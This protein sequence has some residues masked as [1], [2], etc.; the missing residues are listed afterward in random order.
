[1]LVIMVIMGHLMMELLLYLVGQ[2]PQPH[3]QIGGDQMHEAEL[4]QR[5]VSGDVNLQ[6]QV[7]RPT[8]TYRAECLL[9]VH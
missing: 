3:T 8:M 5:S 1:M 4:G 9:Y 2:R 6:L 7:N